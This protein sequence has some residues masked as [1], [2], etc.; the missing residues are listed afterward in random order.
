MGNIQQESAFN[1]GAL[2]KKDLNGYA[3]FGLI[4]W[5]EKYYTRQEVGTALDQQ[6]NF[7]VNMSTYKKFINLAEPKTSVEKAAY[8]FANLVEVCDKCNKGFQIYKSSYQYVRTKY[9][10]DFFSRF[11]DTKDK[12]YW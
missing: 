3:S 9:A 6:L 5:N 8:E 10:N 12:L 7:M 2:N 11:N 1:T 4:Q